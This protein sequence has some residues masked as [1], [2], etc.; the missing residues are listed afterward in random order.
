[1]KIKDLPKDVTVSRDELQAIRGG[2]LEGELV[3]MELA[4]PVPTEEVTLN[5]TEIEW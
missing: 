2:G 4:G 5:Y 3:Q 1:M